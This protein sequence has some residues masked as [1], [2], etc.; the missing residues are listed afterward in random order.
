MPHNA[1]YI[2]KVFSQLKPDEKVWATWIHKEEIMEKVQEQLDNYDD[3][4]EVA[5]ITAEQIVTD[6]FAESVF[7]SI[8]SDDYL[9]ERFNENYVEI[10]CGL[11]SEKLKEIKEDKE[12]WDTEKEK[13]SVIS[14]ANRKG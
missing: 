2:T 7:D 6:D 10:V 12:L 4:S 11:L 8:N 1:D 9:W 5:G 14:N 3:D 13:E